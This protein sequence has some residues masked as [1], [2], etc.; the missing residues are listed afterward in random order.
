MRLLL[1]GWQLRRVKGG[2]SCVGV[3]SM[4]SA[5]VEIFECRVDDCNFQFLVKGR[6][7]IRLFVFK[8]AVNMSNDPTVQA[9]FLKENT[10]R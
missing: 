1:L 9:S 6:K 10:P 7:C 4:A 5:A 3:K 8:N 2:G